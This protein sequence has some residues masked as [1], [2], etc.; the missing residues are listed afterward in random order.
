MY[1]FKYLVDT[2]STINSGIENLP[3]S[4]YWALHPGLWVQNSVYEEDDCFIYTFYIRKIIDY[5][6]FKIQC[7]VWVRSALHCLHDRRF[8]SRRRTPCP[9][10]SSPFSNSSTGRA[11]SGRARKQASRVSPLKSHFCRTVA[12]SLLQ[13]L[14]YAMWPG[15]RGHHFPCQEMTKRSNFFSPH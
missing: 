9:S 3:G 1:T 10:V 8:F 5:A 12:P 7:K 14:Q 2:F 13:N 4:K 11:C 15:G 6:A